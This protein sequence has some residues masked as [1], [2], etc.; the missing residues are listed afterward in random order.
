MNNEQ[1]SSKLVKLDSS[2]Q[3]VRRQNTLL[4]VSG[5]GA[6]V[7]VSPGAEPLIPSMEKGTP[8]DDLVDILAKKHP[9]V[10]NVNPTLNK[11]LAQLS[12]SQ[13]L[14]SDSEEDGAV[15][16]PRKKRKYELM[17]P[18]PL[19]KSIAGAIQKVPAPITWGILAIMMIASIVGA[20]ML[21]SYTKILH[22]S[23]VASSFNIVAFLIFLLVI[24]PIHEA[25]HAIACRL[26]G[27]KVSGAG[28]ILHGGIIP[29]PYVETT[30]AYSLKK[31]S[32]RFWIPAAGPIINLCSAGLM[33]WIII[34]SPQLSPYALEVLVYIF[35]LSML[36]VYLD[37]NPFTASD[38]SHMLEALL[39]DE[40]AR[41]S[42]FSKQASA[43]SDKAGLA[44]YKRVSVAHLLLA[45]VTLI[46][47]WY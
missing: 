20:V 42:A 33:A 22:P 30:K 18:D 5:S 26:V 44:I 16:K 40:L 6:T 41:R 46:Y 4:L 27:S 17:D 32:H 39:D 36:F 11:F 24:V 35:I 45:I 10:P 23:M 19:A 28:I 13:I 34:L 37:T 31:K 1:T 21:P 29:G 3:F 25:G 9:N 15:K 14:E 7:R 43:L 12:K 8:Y 38:G 47:W 2:V